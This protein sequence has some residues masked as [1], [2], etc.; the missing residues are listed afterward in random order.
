MNVLIL[1]ILAGVGALLY[2]Q[3][4][5]AAAAATV[6]SDAA[7]TVSDAV[8]PLTTAWTRFD[9]LFHTYGDKYG[10]DWT[11]LKAFCL[12]ESDLGRVASV[13]RG[14]DSPGDVDG[15]KSSDG[16]SWGLMQVTVTTA[17]GIDPQASAEKLNDPDYSVDLGAHYISQLMGMFPKN[18]PQYVEWVI[19]SYNQGP[20]NTKH[21]AAGIIDGYAETYW[22]R[23][24]R[25]LTRVEE[26]LT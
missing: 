4:P 23:W 17:K 3:K 5:V 9:D 2:W 21:E 13:S 22:E 24:Q 10:V 26:N 8:E 20:G 25:N 18:D 16:K 12:N 6:A 19:K 7:Q 1:G 11:W 15:S 14:L